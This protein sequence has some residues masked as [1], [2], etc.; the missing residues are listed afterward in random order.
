M[1]RTAAFAAATSSVLVAAIGSATKVTNP[2]ELS[3]A[4]RRVIAVFVA[5]IVPLVVTV[6][7]KSATCCK[8][9]PALF[10]A[11]RASLLPMGAVGPGAAL[12]AAVGA[13]VRSVDAS[14]SK[15]RMVLVIAVTTASAVSVVVPSLVA[16]TPGSLAAM[17]VRGVTPRA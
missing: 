3:A 4:F 1:G 7:A 10:S 8:G 12:V 2:A 17:F 14:M 11:I 16:V 5:L 6:F 9:L 15:A 13:V